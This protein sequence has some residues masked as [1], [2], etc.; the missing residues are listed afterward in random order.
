MNCKKLFLLL[1]PF[2]LIGLVNAMDLSD[3]PNMFIQDN[4]FNGIL[5]VSD[6]APADDVIGITDIA[7]S[8]QYTTEPSGTSEGG[9]TVTKI[10]VGT[11]KLA[12]QVTNPDAHNLILVGMLKRD[13]YKGN[14]LIDRYYSGNPSGGL[15][16]LIRNGD[17]YVLIAT[18]DSTINVREATKVLAN[19]GDYNL[20]GMEYEIQGSVEPSCNDSD[21]GKDFYI[22]GVVNNNERSSED[23]CNKGYAVN[24]PSTEVDSCSGSDC[25]AI[26]YYCNGDITTWDRYQ[27]PYGCDDGACKEKEITC[28]DSDNGID[29][30]NKGYVTGAG[31]D[32]HYDFCDTSYPGRLY[33]QYCTSSQ[34]HN[35]NT[36]KYQC[37]YG[38]EDGAC[39]N[40]TK[41]YSDADCPSTTE[42]YC[43]GN[44]A[45]VATQTYKC[46]N[47]G[48]TNAYCEKYT[49][50][51]GCRNC[52][53]GCEDGACIQQQND[54]VGIY[55]RDSDRDGYKEISNCKELQCINNDLKS[56]YELTRDISCSETRNWNSGKGFQPI[57]VLAYDGTRYLGDIGFNGN[58]KGNG[59]VITNLYINRPST[60]DVGLFGYVLHGTISDAGIVDAYITGHDRVGALVG[61]MD[62]R[63]QYK[64]RV[65]NCFS[66]G[67]IN[68]NQRVG[69]LIGYLYDSTMSDSYSTAS[70]AGGSQIGGLLGSYMYSTVS[71]SYATGT[72]TGSEKVGGLIGYIRGAGSVKAKVKN[73]FATGNIMQC[74]GDCGGLI[75]YVLDYHLLTNNAHANNIRDCIGTYTNRGSG[76]SDCAYYGGADNFKDD[77]YPANEPMSF[78]KFFRTWEERKNDYPSLTWQNLGENIGGSDKECKAI[79]S[80][81]SCSYT[82]IEVVVGEARPDCARECIQQSQAPYIPNCGYVNGVCKDLN[83]DR[84]EICGDLLYFTSHNCP[85]CEKQDIVIKKLDEN[86]DCLDIKW[87]NLVSQASSDQGNI[88][89]YDVSAVPTM[90]FIQ[91]DCTKKKIG[92]TDYDA[93][94]HWLYYGSCQDNTCIGEGEEGSRFNNDICCSGLS[95]ID[96]SRKAGDTCV[97]PSD[98]SFVCSYCGNGICGR[99]ENECNCKIDCKENTIIRVNLN[100]KFSLKE[101]QTAYVIDYRNLKIKLNKI[102]EECAAYSS[103]NSGGAGCKLIG[104][105]VSVEMP[106]KCSTNSY[107]E[108]CASTGTEFILKEGESK[109]VFGA[110]LS[111]LDLDRNSGLFVLKKQTQTD[112]VDVY[113]SPESQTINYGDHAKY[114]VTIVDKHPP[115]DCPTGAECL[116]A[117]YEYEINVK[118]L[119]FDKDY[120]KRIKLGAGQKDSFTLIVKP[121][122]VVE[123]S[124]ELVEERQTESR[125]V[126]SSSSTRISK[127]TGN[128][129]AEPVKNIE[130]EAVSIR[131]YYAR[132][133]KFSVTAKLSGNSRIQDSAYAV[134]KINPNIPPPQ[135]PGEEINIKLYKGWN[136][137]SL[138]GKLVTFSDN[139]CTSNRK[140]LGFVYLKEKQKYVSLQEAQEILGDDL[141]E[142]LAKNSFW[143]YSYE[144]CKLRARLD[145]A[146]SYSGINLY[147]GWNLMPITEDMLGGYLGDILSDCEIEK[148]YKWQASK[149]QWD[150][151]TLDYSFLETELSY[152]FLAKA[153]NYCTLGGVDILLPQEMPE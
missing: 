82:C 83:E 146:I 94:K 48:Q 69:G 93:L 23:F 118:N 152:G 97:A 81:C 52:E 148:I 92:Y 34:S 66:T 112:Y 16:K 153:N 116:I 77:V 87:V 59:H 51:A 29:Y 46:R 28:T 25:Y 54:C 49:G 27:C 114:V 108:S 5:V 85:H 74:R 15:I 22:K 103:T 109:E 125:E 43:S 150:K 72:V 31:G 32:I 57:G 65:Y 137:I 75:G 145:M 55:L 12:S 50:G 123:E 133:Y 147:E 134:L 33:E 141:G 64:K 127:I 100:E 110:E 68:G 117:P 95:K 53:Y 78:W 6:T 113:I 10:E 7:S 99:G 96:N 106:S 9:T 38:C 19:Y 47:P 121:Y 101:Q 104:A 60:D 3:Y 126:G 139:G 21:G 149:Q 18:G 132:E 1:M 84:E 61:F 136:L 13:S 98:G 131:P 128:A 17:N 91:D 111:L 70:V 73:S 88:N 40:K 120:P 62:D 124:I 142:Y 63:Y 143:I 45:C 11:T 35:E 36:L 14:H 79:F 115:A 102:I 67:T 37:P 44:S 130:E 80:H 119:P 56:N 105:H 24:R 26:D 151:I 8:L 138:P 90:V 129:V 39:I 89:R 41:C 76:S 71:D 144:E 2:L 140:L 4:G 135:F 42:K 58:F 107:T 20:D 122:N 30:Y 86:I